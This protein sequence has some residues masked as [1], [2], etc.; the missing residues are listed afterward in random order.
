MLCVLKRTVTVIQSNK[1]AA[2]VCS[3]L[4][5]CCLLIT[6]ADS[7][8]PDQMLDLIWVQTVRHSDRVPERSFE[9]VDFEKNLLSTTKA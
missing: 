5:C 7:L 2:H 8:D 4:C 1:V 3:T 6:F 9:R